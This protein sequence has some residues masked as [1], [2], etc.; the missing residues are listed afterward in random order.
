MIHVRQTSS[1][2][3]DIIMLKIFRADSQGFDFLV[4][5]VNLQSEAK[6]LAPSILCS[7]GKPIT[8]DGEIDLTV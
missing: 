5:Y 6:A 7:R 8:S 1:F 4:R 3:N 2:Q